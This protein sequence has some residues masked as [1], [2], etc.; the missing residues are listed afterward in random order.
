M[1][2]KIVELTRGWTI[3]FNFKEYCP[4]KSSYHV[5]GARLLGFCY[6]DYLRYCRTLGAEIRGTQGYSFPVSGG[7][8][9]RRKNSVLSIFT[10]QERKEKWISEAT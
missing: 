2:I 3:E 8:S 5:I 6:P 7:V 4:F 1:E 9:C 10:P